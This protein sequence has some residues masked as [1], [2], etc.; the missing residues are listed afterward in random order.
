EKEK[1]Q[2]NGVH[3]RPVDAVSSADFPLVLT[4]LPGRQMILTL[5]YDESRYDVNAITRMLEHFQTLLNGMALDPHQKLSQLPFLT[6]SEQHQLLVEWNDT[7][8]DYP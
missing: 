3:I 7:Q 6:Q 5:K 4:A 8:T 1:E 2:G